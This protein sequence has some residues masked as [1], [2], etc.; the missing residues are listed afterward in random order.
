MKNER[1]PQ[2]YIM[3]GVEGRREGAV[4][5]SMSVWADQGAESGVGRPSETHAKK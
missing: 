2:E 4:M 3:K 1:R 5:N